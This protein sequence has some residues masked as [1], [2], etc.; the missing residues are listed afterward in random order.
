MFWVLRDSVDHG[1]TIIGDEEARPWSHS[2]SAKLAVT[3]L[4]QRGPTGRRMT[5]LKGSVMVAFPANS[6]LRQPA[7]AVAPSLTSPSGARRWETSTI[8]HAPSRAQRLFLARLFFNHP[9]V[10]PLNG[11]ATL[12]D[13]LTAL[14]QAGPGCSGPTFRLARQPG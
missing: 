14:C 1:S 10:S 12:N 9:R 11:A 13:V 8:I 7:S 2:S 3:L 5:D 4:C 6:P